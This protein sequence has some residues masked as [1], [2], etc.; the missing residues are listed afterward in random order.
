MVVILSSKPLKLTSIFWHC[1]EY[2]QVRNALSR[3]ASCLSLNNAAGSQPIW[4]VVV[5]FDRLLKSTSG[6]V[7]KLILFAV[8]IFWRVKNTSFWHSSLRASCLTFNSAAGTQPRKMVAT[9]SGRA[10]KS[11]SISVMCL[12]LDLYSLEHQ[13]KNLHFCQ[14]SEYQQ[15]R[16]ALS[17][18]RVVFDV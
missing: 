1:S 12:T 15:I 5:Q 10:L 17:R 7:T 8:L 11:T 4:P 16:N 2:P 14:Y 13:P 18:S 3:R 6:S 9:L